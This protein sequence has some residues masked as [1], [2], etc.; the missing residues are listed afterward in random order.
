MCNRMNA[1][2]FSE[3]NPINLNCIELMFK[4][5][6]VQSYL[7]K[8]E[9]PQIA[10]TI[11]HTTKLCSRAWFHLLFLQ[12]CQLHD[13]GLL[14][15]PIHWQMINTSEMCNKITA[16]I[17]SHAWIPNIYCARHDIAL[18]PSYSRKKKLFSF[19]C[20]SIDNVD[21]L[22]FMLEYIVI[23][24][25]IILKPDTNKVIETNY[26]ISFLLSLNTSPSKLINM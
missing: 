15:R 14:L 23:K 4:S 5:G 16:F 22:C 3:R 20:L 11:K 10:K 7:S 24:I 2:I 21:C 26:S 18:W 12:M 6:G 19:K 1:I 13:N 17:R 9:K 8:M 25:A